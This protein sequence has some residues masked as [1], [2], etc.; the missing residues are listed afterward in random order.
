MLWKAR[1][2]FQVVPST[3]LKCSWYILV[4]ERKELWI[5]DPASVKQQW[6]NILTCYMK[7]IKLLHFEGELKLTEWIFFPDLCSLRRYLNYGAQFDILS[8]FFKLL[9][10]LLK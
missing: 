7:S 6:W 10:Y 3:L 4:V 8:K 2:G 9:F 1:L 5:G